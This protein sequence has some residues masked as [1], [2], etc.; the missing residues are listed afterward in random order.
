MNWHE[1]DL[2]QPEHLARPGGDVLLASVPARDIE[3]DGPHI[4]RVAD[5][6]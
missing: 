3:H 5:R 1:G 2:G 6:G 4:F